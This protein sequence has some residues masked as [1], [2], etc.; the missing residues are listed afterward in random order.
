MAKLLLSIDYYRPT[1][2]T[3]F[4]ITFGV[5]RSTLGPADSPSTS[6]IGSNASCIE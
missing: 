3:V 1:R 6:R 5:H 2:R 4:F